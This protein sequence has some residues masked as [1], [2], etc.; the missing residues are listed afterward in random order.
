[1]TVPR[2]REINEQTARAILRDLGIRWGTRPVMT[3]TKTRTY[4]AV[5]RRSGDWWAIS[6]PELRGLHSQARRL[7]Q[8]EAMARD[9]IA[10]F[11]NADPES[12]AVVVKPQTPSEVTDAV[13]ARADLLD[14]E[15][16]AETAT[17]IA[18]ERL[19]KEGYTVRDAGKLLG[20]SPQR[21]SQI[22]TN[23]SDR[24]AT[25]AARSGRV[26]VRSATSSRSVTSK[27]RAA[28]V[29]PKEARS[30]TRT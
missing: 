8:V 9:A 25:S 5:C 6:V 17:K 22:A 26:V 2:H 3:T 12:I 14:A 10:L 15:R 4:T 27:T 23:V 21:V 28:K 18:V 11:L 13:K 19:L 16:K 24:R 1:V 29:I 7:D 30:R 20:I